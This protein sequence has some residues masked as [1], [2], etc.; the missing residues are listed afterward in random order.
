MEISAGDSLH[1]S[2]A[3][4]FATWQGHLP[5]VKWLVE[6]C[7]VDAGA[8]N[9]DG[10][11]G[12]HFAAQESHIDVAQ[13]LAGCL[14]VDPNLKNNDG[15][16]PYHF[17]CWEGKLE[18]TQWMIKDVPEVDTACTDKDGC[19]FMVMVTLSLVPAMLASLRRGGASCN[20]TILM[21]FVGTRGMACVVLSSV[22]LPNAHRSTRRLPY[23]PNIL[24]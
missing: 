10:D 15:N 4:H 23:R 2:S 11:T 18:I 1:R 22:N 9:N 7:G 12:L 5:V 17:A 19:A 21:E 3:L 8:Q 24:L 13:F 20:D 14:G 6:D 16:T